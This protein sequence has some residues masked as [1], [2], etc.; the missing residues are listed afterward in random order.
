MNSTPVVYR[1]RL[2]V[3]TRVFWR[4][5]HMTSCKRAFVSTSTIIRCAT[6]T[7]RTISVQTPTPTSERLRCVH[8]NIGTDIPSGDCGGG[9]GA[10]RLAR[11]S[12]WREIQYP[13][14]LLRF[15]HTGH[16]EVWHEDDLKQ[17]T[18]CL[19]N[20]V[21]CSQYQVWEH[22]RGLIKRK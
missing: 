6:R 14:R 7:Q 4:V 3:K 9:G 17:M 20:M 18:Q 22:W 8:I 16:S 11:G 21:R 2:F 5:I 1:L 13:R 12:R 19:I 10:F 15:E